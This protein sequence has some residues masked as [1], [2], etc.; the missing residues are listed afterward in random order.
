VDWLIIGFIA[1]VALVV[2]WDFENKA[3]K[4][5]ARLKTIESALER[6]DN[7]LVIIGSDTAR[8]AEA[9]DGEQEIIEEEWL[10]EN[11][12]PTLS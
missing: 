5:A 3:N 1:V 4:L 10:R 12:K 7:K 9:L 8:T 11:H 2:R 6:I